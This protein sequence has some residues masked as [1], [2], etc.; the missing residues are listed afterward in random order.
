MPHPPQALP[1]MALA[2]LRAYRETLRGI[3][4]DVSYW[5]RVLHGRID[6]L[7]K[8]VEQRAGNH[9][10]W[11]VRTD[12]LASALKD[13]PTGHSRLALLRIESPEDLPGLPELPGLNELWARDADLADSAAVAALLTA[14]TEAGRQVSEY[15]RRIFTRIDDAA[16]ELIS[17]YQDDPGACLK[18]I[19]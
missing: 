2:D 17:R 8:F 10:G 14:L 5:R 6:L 13:T 19:D 1:D 15:R 3:E 16:G 18:L 7:T 9:P 12:E 11:P 4:E